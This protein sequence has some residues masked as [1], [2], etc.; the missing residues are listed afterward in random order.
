[1]L[2]ECSVIRR[3]CVLLTKRPWCGEILK[4][5]NPTI[6]DFRR[7]P[8]LNL[9]LLWIATCTNVNRKCIKKMNSFWKHLNFQWSTRFWWF[10]RPGFSAQLLLDTFSWLHLLHNKYGTIMKQKRSQIRL[11]KSFIM[12]TIFSW[13]FRDKIKRRKDNQNVK[14]DLNMKLLTYEKTRE[15]F[16]LSTLVY[17]L[18]KV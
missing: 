3:W 18:S 17:L 16:C 12:N 14:S 2:F 9:I 4:S 6:S 8:L 1:M 5:V 13:K 7:G 11:K 10:K 15:C